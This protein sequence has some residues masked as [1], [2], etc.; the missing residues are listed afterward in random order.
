M[1]LIA[2]SSCLLMNL[3][4]QYWCAVPR[5]P[6]HVLLA[7]P[8]PIIILPDVLPLAAVAALVRFVKKPQR[9]HACSHS[10]FKGWWLRGFPPVPSPVAPLFVMYPLRW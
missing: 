10:S 9:G 7:H 5:A 4:R 8:S 6:R 1:M 2:L 3:L